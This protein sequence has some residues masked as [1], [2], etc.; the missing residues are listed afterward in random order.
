M[1]RVIHMVAI[2][3]LFG[4]CLYA[5]DWTTVTGSDLSGYVP[6]PGVKLVDRA[7]DIAL[8]WK[9]DCPIPRTWN[10]NHGGYGSPLVYRGKVYLFYQQ[11]AAEFIDHDPFH[12]AE[13]EVQL[14][15]GYPYVAFS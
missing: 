7:A 1:K 15:G 14:F 8:A 3:T 6:L 9:S 12:A 11:H 4:G 5:A 13:R 2:L 10:D